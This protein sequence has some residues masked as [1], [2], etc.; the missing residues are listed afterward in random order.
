MIQKKINK[1]DE[2]LVSIILLSYNSQKDLEECIP[3]LMNQTYAN[4]EIILIDNASKDKT[5]EFVKINYPD[6]KIIKNERNIGYAEGNN[7]GVRYAKGEYIVILN[8]DTITERDW[9]YQLIKPLKDYHASTSKILM[10]GQRDTINTCGNHSHFTGIDFCRGLYENISC[11]SKVEDVNSISGCSFAIRKD[12]F[13]KIGGFDP[14]F[15]LYLEDIDLSWRLRIA[16]YKIVFVPTSIIYH[17][18]Q[19]KVPP[20]KEFYLEKNRYMMLIK[21]YNIQTLVLI[22]PALLVTEFIIWVHAITNGFKYVRSKLKAYWWI[23]NNFDKII[24][25]RYIVQ[26]H[27]KIDDKEFIRLLE[28]KIPFDYLIKNIPAEAANIIFNSFFLMNFILVKR[29]M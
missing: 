16:G 8:P 22:S 11:F 21:N 9:L 14:D 13:E 26:R 10:H 24:R 15:F 20:M 2:K 3:S 29:L 18:F 12:I 23:Y 19:L 17:K 4:Y 27:R 6:I 1:K 5:V 7:I 25:K 28:W